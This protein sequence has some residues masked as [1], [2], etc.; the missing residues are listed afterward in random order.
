MR[1]P[2][3]RPDR[4]GQQQHRRRLH[5]SRSPDRI[6]RS[7]DR[8]ARDR[9]D[10]A[11]VRPCEPL[12][13]AQD[14]GGR[15]CRRPRRAHPR[16][17]RSGRRL[18][19]RR[20]DGGRRACQRVH[21]QR[22]LRPVRGRRTR[23]VPVA[24]GC[25]GG[26]AC[27]RGQR[28]GRTRERAACK[29][30]CNQ[31]FAGR[32]RATR[33]RQPSSSGC[34]HEPDGNA[35]RARNRHADDGGSGGRLR[36]GAGRLCGARGERAPAGNG[37]VCDGT[38][39]GRRP[40]GRLLGTHQS[41]R[42]RHRERIARLPGQVR[43]RGVGHRH[44][45]IHRRQQQRVA[46]GAEL[47]G[48]VRRR[49]AGRGRPGRP[50]RQ[51][52]AHR[53]AERDGGGTEPGPGAR[54]HRPRAGPGLRAPGPL[55]R[56]PAR[57]RDVRRSRAGTA[58]R[59]ARVA[60]SRLLRQRQFERRDRLPCPA[61]QDADGR[62][63]H[64]RRGNHRRRRGPAVPGRRGHRRGF[65]RPMRSSTLALCLPRRNRFRCASGCD[66]DRRSAT[67][68]SPTTGPPPTPTAQ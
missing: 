66:C 38:D 10:A 9:D 43:R 26:P 59:H 51:R 15:P 37:P 5:A 61:A 55:E 52:G 63:G 30:L 31:L 4:H 23:P 3:P 6:V 60:G 32:N 40:H 44:A 54:G 58:C 12:C 14:R 22:R 27:R 67:T 29:H 8:H 45:A 36:E 34:R 19:A 20:R 11:R 62:S 64:R 25:A 2:A 24:A 50:A 7:R 18:C 16:Q 28:A 68:P 48:A 41:R 57:I 53:A 35:G 65:A 33:R 17:S 21:G 47:C 49:T 13:A 42:V 56:D 1:S 39:R 46:P